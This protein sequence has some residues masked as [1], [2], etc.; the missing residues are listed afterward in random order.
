[1]KV[2]KEGYAKRLSF[3]I[4]FPIAEKVESII[5]AVSRLE[6]SSFLQDFITAAINSSLVIKS[7]CVMG[8]WVAVYWK[9][10]SGLNFQKSLIDRLAQVKQAIYAA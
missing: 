8:G 1:V 2:P 3:L 6:R 5:S 9:G 10:T 7:S 4:D